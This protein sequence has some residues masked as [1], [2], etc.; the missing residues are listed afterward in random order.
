MKR[1]AELQVDSELRDAMLPVAMRVLKS[2]R[3]TN[4]TFTIELVSADGAPFHFEPGQF[5]MI[6]LLG[7]GEVPISISG[8]PDH[9]SVLIHTIR[10][11]GA[12]TLAL[13]R[14][15]TGDWVTVRGPYGR[16]WPMDVAEGRDVVLVCG[17]IGLAPLRP[18]IYRVL[19]HPTRYG[20]LIVLYGA[21]TR[22]DILFEKELGNW[23]S[24][25]DSQIEVTLDRGSEGWRGNVGVVTELIPRAHVDP[26]ESVA[27]I[28]GP[29]IMMRFAYQALAARG[30]SDEMT[31]ASMERNMKC[32]I[33][34]CGHCQARGD[35]MCKTGPVFKFSEVASLISTREL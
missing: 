30:L 2:R 11:V 17:G 3:E 20:K 19:N 15:K 23:R 4:D 16:P 25:F 32:G 22:K 29:E 21:R 28:C 35:F 7:V 31:Y 5:N 9:P 14:V 8:D 1:D 33:G 27:M 26:E 24:H 10:E 13:G 12:V 18:V 34:L 6:G